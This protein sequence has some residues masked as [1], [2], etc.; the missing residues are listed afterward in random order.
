[1]VSV[2]KSSG[3]L[4]YAEY[5]PAVVDPFWNRV[6]FV[7]IG[8][9]GE[10]GSYTAPDMTAEVLRVVEKNGFPQDHAKDKLPF[11]VIAPL[12]TKGPSIAD[13][14]LIAK[15][16]GSIA[17]EIDVD[18]RFISGLSQGG[19]SVSGFLFQSRNSTELSKGSP[20]QYKNADVF[21]GFVIMC[22]KIPSSPD[23]CAFPEKAV[24]II[25]ATGDTA[26]P[27]SN[28]LNIMN[29]ANSC[30][31]RVEDIFANFKQTWKGSLMTWISQGFPA[32]VMNR[33]F[34]I[35]GGSHATSWTE[36]Y[37]WNGVPGSAGNELKLWAEK[38]ARRKVKDIPIE[39]TALLDEANMTATFYKKDGNVTYGLWNLPGS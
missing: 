13:H 12:A 24:F 6:L 10:T 34:I 5:P 8:G 38:V 23:I 17:Q 27:I 3:G 7:C 21:D 30:V 20:S 29:K 33:M 28:G 39:V 25:H 32:D 1:M 36:G 35:Q 14:T 31:N 16:I 11:W 15:E 26:V 37:N 19:E 4:W 9:S 2:K 18:V 22:G